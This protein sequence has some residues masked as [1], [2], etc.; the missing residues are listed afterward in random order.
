MDECTA[1]S[2]HHPWHERSNGN[3]VTSMRTTANKNLLLSTHSFSRHTDKMSAQRTSTVVNTIVRNAVVV[4]FVVSTILVITVKV[5]VFIITA[6]SQVDDQQ[7]QS[8]E[9]FRNLVRQSARCRFVDLC[10][11]FLQL[12]FFVWR[13]LCCCH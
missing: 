8:H 1:Y 10:F 9:G 12:P 13:L 4:V 5:I 7:R 6:I 11:S 3:G 2:Q